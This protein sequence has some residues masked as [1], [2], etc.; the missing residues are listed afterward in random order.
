[1]TATTSEKHRSSSFS[2]PRVVPL[3]ELYKTEFMLPADVL[4][5]TYS[6]GYFM[7]KTVINT[8]Q[9]PNSRSDSRSTDD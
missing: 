1:V 6:G 5:F 3:P 8:E 4:G 7:E 2:L 9:S